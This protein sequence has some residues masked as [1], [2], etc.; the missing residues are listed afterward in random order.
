MRATL[1]KLLLTLLLSVASALVSAG[2]ASLL[3]ESDWG[4]PWATGGD[5]VW[6]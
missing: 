6:V 5:A 2:V 4:A 1:W 3:Q